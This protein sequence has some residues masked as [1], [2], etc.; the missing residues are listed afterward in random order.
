MKST[1]VSIRLPDCDLAQID[2]L[3]GEFSVERAT[4]IRRLVTVGV[5]GL[6]RYE[7]YCESFD[8]PRS[9]RMSLDIL[10]SGTCA[11]EGIE[12]TLAKIVDVSS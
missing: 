7:K 11:E 12:K 1:T 8:W 10:P 6:L 2:R 3:A 9:G 4:I 5:C